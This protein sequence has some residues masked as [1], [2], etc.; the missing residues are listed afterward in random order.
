MIEFV[1]NHD[2]E[3]TRFIQQEPSPA[4]DS[5]GRC[6]TIGVIDGDG[7]LIAGLVYYNYDP[8]A[9]T[10]EMGA[11]AVTPRWF[12]RAT[13]RRMFEYP[14]VECGCQMLYARIPVENEYLLSQFARMNFNLTMVPRMYGRS[15]DGVLC[16]LT[17]DQWLDS[18]IAKRIYRDVRREREAA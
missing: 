12:T 2:N 13:Y 18:A 11:R 10:M 4:G 6:K 1:Y 15:E 9:E 5:Y 3:V 8:S 16:T 7:R 14:F 17:D